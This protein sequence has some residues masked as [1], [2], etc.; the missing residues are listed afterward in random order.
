MT[1]RTW[2][3]VGAVILLALGLSLGGPVGAAP[4]SPLTIAA[5]Y[6][7][8]YGAGGRHWDDGYLRERLATAQEPELGEYDSFS[9][10]TVAAHFRWAQ[11]YGVDVF[12]CSWSAPG[13]YEDIVL[14]DRLLS[15]PARG[16]TRMAILYESKLRL[17]ST[18]GR[19]VFD[20]EKQER[21]L[22]DFDY[23]AERY[24]SDPA[25]FRL[26]GRPVV[27]LYVS[28]I[29]SGRYGAAIRALRAYV[30]ERHGIDLYLVG[31]EVD[32]DD[33]PERSRIRLFDAITSYTMY[34][35]HQPA[36]W[37]ATTRFL[38]KV[39]R[40]YGQFSRVAASEGVSFIPGALPGFNDRGIRP[41]E[42]HYVLPH[43]V[44][45]RHRDDYTLFS[46]FLEVAGEN[47]DPRLNLLTVTSWNEWHEDTQIEPTA[48]RA[49]ST[50]P[51]EWT[52]GYPY[53]SY[54]HRLLELL[55]A[56][57]ARFDSPR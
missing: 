26:G 33:P 44:S 42:R 35:R 12:I 36:G 39:D 31:D 20:K 37:P 47:V 7:A 45:G 43:E 50:G 10:E 22:S 16:D 46:R 30:R 25:Y 28:R 24:F 15:S 18:N 41:D 17:G 11:R 56:F 51:N 32:P 52:A 23:L 9:E 49:P 19:I 14:R 2:R 1:R 5:Y 40:R 8:W 34:S 48:P 4:E 21:L 38:Q 6:Y 13:S 53:Y 54:G 3:A 55:A 57:A 27:V 29:F